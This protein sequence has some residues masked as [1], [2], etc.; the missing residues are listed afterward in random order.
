V[1]ITTYAELKTAIVSWLDV[2]TATFTSQIDDLVTVGEKRLFRE[3]RTRDMESAIS[4]VI[5]GGFIALPTDYVAIKYAYI[6]GSSVCR[7]E[8]RPAD[9]I[10][11]AYPVRTASGKPKYIARESTN[12][13]FGPF[14]DSAYTVKGIYYRRQALIANTPNALFLA[15]PDLYLFSCLAESESLIGRDDRIALW[16]AKYQRILADV[17]GEDRTEDASGGGLQ[18]RVA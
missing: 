16:E 15:N 10:Y 9:W 3:A 1:S 14:P 2:P 8:R 5:A 17:N 18:M 13:I 6:D 12:F 11:Q 7:L 4:S